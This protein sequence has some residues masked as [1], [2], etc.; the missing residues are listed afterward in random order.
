MNDP[1]IIT[2][3]DRAMQCYLRIGCWSARKLDTKATKK[4]TDGASATSDAAR[5]NKHLLASADEKLRA[6]AKIGGEARRYLED[7]T[8]P[9]D[10]AGNRL[11]PNESAIEVVSALTEYEK[12]FGEAVTDFIHEYPMLR[13]QAL[14]NLGDLA[15]SEDYPLP[16]QVRHRFSFR[17]SFTPV[18]KGFA[19][20]RTGLSD[21]QVA[22]LEQHYQSNA[23][24][25]VGD[26]LTS[27]WLRLKDN[28]SKYSDR[29][30]EKDD[31]SGKME[32]FR[33]SMVENLRETCA[34]LKTLNVFDDDSLERM[35][36]RVERDIAS[37]DANQLREST[38]LAVSV[39]SEVDAVL[40]AMKQMMGE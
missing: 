12:R 2:I 19:D 26:A 33:D 8:L 29:L 13:E 20:V 37:F 11:L 6:I 31:G 27:A 28:L 25:Q 16:D 39:K 22:A 3:H 4:V 35:R 7:K 38:V 14:A 32:I 17:L 9:W 1:N 34:L 21:E 24:R 23:R 30:R 15:D 18:A 36:I 5:V 40:E 10:D